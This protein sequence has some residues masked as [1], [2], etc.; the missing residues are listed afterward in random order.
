[1]NRIELQARNSQF[2]DSVSCLKES[3][4]P[5]DYLKANEKMLREEILGFGY[6]MWK[7][8]ITKMALERI[9][10]NDI[11]VYMYAGCTINLEGQKRFYEYIKMLVISRFSNLSFET[12][13]KEIQYTKGDLFNYFHVTDNEIIK[14]S[15]MLIAT[16]F[17]I[18]KDSE[19]VKLVNE[20]YT[21]CHNNSSL[22]DNSPSNYPNDKEFIAHRFDQSIFSLLRKINGTLIVKDET[23]FN[24]WNENKRFPIHG[25][26]LKY[27]KT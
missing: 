18:Q 4:L 2:F 12:G 1:M 14:N 7:S 16:T 10:D 15:G 19:S 3:D 25:T 6:W 24:N 13:Q 17:F 5:I 22:I 8:F 21:L 26:K 11:L 23:W 9:D 20:W 27:V